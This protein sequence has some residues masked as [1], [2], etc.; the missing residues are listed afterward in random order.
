MT[1]RVPILALIAGTTVVSPVIA[2]S[3]IVVAAQEA[4]A[5]VTL[6]QAPVRLINLP[7]LTFQVRAAIHC[8]GEPISVTLS[9]AD[10]FS[11]QDRDQLAGQRATEASLTVPARQLAIAA[12]SRFCVEDNP[13]SEDELLMPG[14]ATVH[15]SLQ[16]ENETGVT[17]RYASAP[18]SVRLSCARESDESASE[19]ANGQESSLDR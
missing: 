16:C 1:G 6:R 9:V 11:T 18:L 19:S 15:A 8:K 3:E 17:V 7:S 4:E 13:D 14:F 12:S 10:T 2:D 5:E